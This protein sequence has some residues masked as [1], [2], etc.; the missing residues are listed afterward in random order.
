M[1]ETIRRQK[2]EIEE[3]VKMAEM[4]VGDLED[5]GARLGGV[6]EELARDGREVEGVLGGI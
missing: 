3:L 2:T 6:G 5:A 1:I 4:V